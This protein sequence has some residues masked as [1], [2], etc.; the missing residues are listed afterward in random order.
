MRAPVE[1]RGEGALEAREVKLGGLGHAGIAGSEDGLVEEVL[2]SKLLLGEVGKLVDTVD[3]GTLIGVQLF[4]AVEG[5]SELCSVS[6]MRVCLN[7][8]LTIW[9]RA[10]YSASEA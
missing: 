6:R 1:G 4:N 2:G 3:E 7:G 10:S 5:L 8:E 9:K